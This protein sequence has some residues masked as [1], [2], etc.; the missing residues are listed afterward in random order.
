MIIA[1]LVQGHIMEKL[2]FQ[3]LITN[4]S[5]TSAPSQSANAAN[6]TNQSINNTSRISNNSQLIVEESIPKEK[7]QGR[8]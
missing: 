1:Y 4:T 5:K 8:N 2:L 6:Q 3:Y 7:E